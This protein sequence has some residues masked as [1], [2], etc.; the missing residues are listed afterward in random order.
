LI[1]EI[2]PD[3]PEPAAANALQEG[4]RSGSYIYNSR[5]LVLDQLDNLKLQAPAGYRNAGYMR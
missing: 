5:N 1:N 3:E 4:L 2:L